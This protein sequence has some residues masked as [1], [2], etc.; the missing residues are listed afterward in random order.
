MLFAF[1]KQRACERLWEI[2]SVLCPHKGT[3]TETDL[4]VDAGAFATCL[5]T[6]CLECGRGT[7]L[8]TDYPLAALCRER[9]SHVVLLYRGGLS[10]IPKATYLAR[11]SWVART[12]GADMLATG[13]LVIRY[14]RAAK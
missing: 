13:I 8:G 1:L 10:A 9:H 5:A 2:V 4:P 12:D 3:A 14:I 7:S 11:P 6:L